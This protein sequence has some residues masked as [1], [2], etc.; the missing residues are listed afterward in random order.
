MRKCWEFLRR[1]A[2]LLLLALVLL[3]GDLALTRLDPVRSMTSLWRSDYELIALEHPD[4]T[5]DRA[6]FGS[7]VVI[8]SYI[9]GQNPTGYVNLGIDYG[10]VADITEMLEGG[11]VTVTGDLVLGLNDI[12][13]YDPLPTNNAYPWHR[14]WYEPY[15]YFHRDRLG[16]LVTKGAENLLQGRPFVSERFPDQARAVY[17]GAISD[18]ELAKSEEKMLEQFGSMT[19]EDCAQNFAALDRLAAWCAGHGVRLR[20]VWMPW[21]PKTAVYPA[22]RTLMDYAN[23]RFDRL[24]IEV[25]DL[26]DAVPEEYFYDMGHLDYT[27]GAPW[28]TDLIDPWLAEEG[29]P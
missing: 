15:L 13:F 28:F 19:L 20:A 12:S 26:T 14:R 2:F 17:Y 10:T 9:E 23:E 8:A 24:G 3:L 6:F 22:A 4:M 27:A 25:L 7:S 5:F 1:N 11:F 21:N 29:A 18:E 16:P